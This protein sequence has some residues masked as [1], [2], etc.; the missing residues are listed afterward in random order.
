MKDCIVGIFP[1]VNSASGKLPILI[2]GAKVK[3]CRQPEVGGRWS[4]KKL[5]LAI[6][7]L[8]TTATAALASVLQWSVT[9]KEDPFDN[10]GKMTLTY[11]DSRDS[12][13]LI[14]CE[15]GSSTITIRRATSFPYDQSSPPASVVQMAIIV[16]K[17]ESHL[18]FASTDML[19]TGNIGFDME[20]SDDSARRLLNEMRDGK[21]K[22]FMKIGEAD[23]EEFSLRGSTKAADRALQFCF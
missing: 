7:V 11:I 16:D 3:V 4:L 1:P 20:R 15:Q 23:P 8:L 17:G 9:V 6:T 10:K 21:S 19:G 14:M 5:V 18:G 22:M 2:S 12:G 13:V